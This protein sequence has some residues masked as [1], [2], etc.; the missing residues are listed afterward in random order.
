LTVQKGKKKKSAEGGE[1]DMVCPGGGRG[2]MDS[3]G[4]VRARQKVW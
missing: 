3:H 2:G 4:G 1:K